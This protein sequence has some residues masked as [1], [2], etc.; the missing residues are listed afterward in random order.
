MRILPLL[1][2]LTSCT[3]HP[4]DKMS[5]LLLLDPYR[6]DTN[7]DL[8]YECNL[9]TSK[10][11]EQNIASLHKG[12]GVRISVYSSTNQYELFKD[13]KMMR[14]QAVSEDFDDHLKK[15][16]VIPI[17]A[18]L[19]LKRAEDFGDTKKL[20]SYPVRILNNTLFESYQSKMIVL[21][22][23]STIPLSQ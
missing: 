10:T 18:E 2:L 1:L 7:F 14:N 15:V 13:S 19:D 8:F 16:L 4:K 12:I 22:S 23:Y 6:N 3:V 9:D 20:Y 21:K 17:V 5:G 11:L